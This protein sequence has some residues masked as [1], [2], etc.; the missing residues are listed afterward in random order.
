MILDINGNMSEFKKR[1]NYLKSQLSL[2]LPKPGQIYQQASPSPVGNPEVPFRFQVW[3]LLHRW[4]VRTSRTY[5]LW[6]S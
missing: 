5:Q 6:P 3:S 1:I 2:L 4:R